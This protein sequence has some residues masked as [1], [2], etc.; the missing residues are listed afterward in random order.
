MTRLDQR[1]PRGYTPEQLVQI[2]RSL[3]P[4]G[5]LRSAWDHRPGRRRRQEGRVEAWRTERLSAQDAHDERVVQ[6]TVLLKTFRESVPGQE[7]ETHRPNLIKLLDYAAKGGND[8]YLKEI[9]NGTIQAEQLDVLETIAGKLVNGGVMVSPKTGERGWEWYNTKLMDL[10]ADVRAEQIPSGTITKLGIFDYEP[11]YSFRGRTGRVTIP[12][13][14]NLSEGSDGNFNIETWTGRYGDEFN[15][16]VEIF[17][18]LA[19][20]LARA[21]YFGIIVYGIGKEAYKSNI[22]GAK[23]I[24]DALAGYVGRTLEHRRPIETKYHPAE[25]K[26]PQPHYTPGRGGDYVKQVEFAGKVAAGN[27]ARANEYWSNHVEYDSEVANGHA[28]IDTLLQ[29]LATAYKF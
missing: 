14:A 23:S 3:A 12:A 13:R 19:E 2:E 6:A 28:V 11:G 25:R 22:A 10:T 15:N 8:S 24:A 7:F 9:A 20:G 4:K 5:I 16:K 29:D 21:P 27:E 18:Q 1:Q 17:S 26:A